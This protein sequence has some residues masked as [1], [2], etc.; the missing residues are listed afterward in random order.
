MELRFEIIPEKKLIGKWIRMSLTG[1]RTYE[2]WRG[3]MPERKKISNAVS[4]DLFSM[5]VYDM[6]YNFNNLDPGKEFDKWAVMEVTDIET[7]PEGMEPFILKGGLYA[8]FIHKGP[9]SSGEY[10]FR[11]IFDTW[12][13]GSGYKI[14]YRPHFEILGEKYKHEDPSSEEE[15]WIPVTAI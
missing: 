5:Q 1:N 8:V 9:A 14:D 4:G 7:I 15:I 10:T 12:L 2:L 3:F 13:P 11:Y 6:D